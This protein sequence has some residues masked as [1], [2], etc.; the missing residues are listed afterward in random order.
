MKRIKEKSMDRFELLNFLGSRWFSK[1]GGDK[2]LNLDVQYGQMPPQRQHTISSLI[3]DSKI[4]LAF[5]ISF[6]W[7]NLFSNIIEGKTKNFCEQEYFIFKVS[8]VHM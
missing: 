3:L 6:A 8:V 5:V 4:D 2:S 1:L 7:L